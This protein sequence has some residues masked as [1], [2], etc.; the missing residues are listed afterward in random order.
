MRVG[1]YYYYG[2]FQAFSQLCTFREVVKTRSSSSVGPKM[3]ETSIRTCLVLA[4]FV[5]ISAEASKVTFVG[6]LNDVQNK[7]FSALLEVELSA[8]DNAFSGRGLWLASKDY[9]SCTGRAVYGRARVDPEP[10][11]PLSEQYNSEIRT[12]QLLLPL[13]PD[14]EERT[15]YLCTR[16]A[17][18]RWK[19]LGSASEFLLPKVTDVQVLNEENE[20]I[21]EPVP[22]GK[23]L[24]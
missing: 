5:V 9:K 12:L 17:G 18:S 19:P 15:L 6:F 16:A 3:A 10:S 20:Y 24:F 8:E 22:A 4:F 11:G 1:E 21:L 23:L 13:L 2:G 7:Q 14:H